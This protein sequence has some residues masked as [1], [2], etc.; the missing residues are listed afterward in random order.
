L[1]E[2]DVPEGSHEEFK[3]LR[4]SVATDVFA[5]TRCLEQALRAMARSRKLRGRRSGLLDRSRLAHVA[6]SLSKHVFTERT[7]G[8]T[9]HTAV[10][11]VIDESGSMD[12]YHDVSRVVIALGEAL[13]ACG[14][15]FEV[16]G[17]TTMYGGGDSF[18][19]DLDGFSRVNPIVY[20]HYKAFSEAWPSVCSRLSEVS[21][22]IHHIDGEVVEY[23][24]AR[25]LGRPETRKV[26]ISVSDGLP[27]SGQSNDDEMRANLVKVCER[28]REAGVEVYSV[29]LFTDEPVGYYGEK[30][31]VVIN[32]V[33]SFGSDFARAM[34]S[35][36][37][38]GR[39]R[40][41]GM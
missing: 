4:G 15:P 3:E 41:A 21:A 31:S 32:D 20:K 10:E 35:V 17:A 40:V 24:A 26:V 18:L 27:Q 28:A 36:L 22:M 23:A 8:E 7:E 5:I 1:D 38:G 33:K 6:K 11:I 29:S 19:K 39:L 34:V 16:T 37:T 30:N 2:H 12:H 14:I 25:L 13:S 9:L